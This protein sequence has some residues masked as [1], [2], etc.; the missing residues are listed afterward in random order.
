MLWLENGEFAEQ[1]M[2]AVHR[3][4][5]C[6]G[7]AF[8]GRSRSLVIVEQDG[9]QCVAQVPLDIVSQHA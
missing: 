6:S 5:I 3:Q 1:G 9:C 7:A 4:R 2:E 8:R